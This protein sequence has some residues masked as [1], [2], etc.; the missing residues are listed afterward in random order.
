MSALDWYFLKADLLG[1]L[2]IVDARE[3]RE[4]LRECFYSGVSVCD[5]LL[6]IAR[7]D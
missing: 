3:W 5:A 4:Y 6:E 2:F 1:I 7:T